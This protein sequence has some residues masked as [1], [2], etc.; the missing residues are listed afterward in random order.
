MRSSAL[1]ASWSVMASRSKTGVI[2]DR[3][4][5]WKGVIEILRRK[6]IAGIWPHNLYG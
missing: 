4:K 2:S 5:T 3:A 6:K 1:P